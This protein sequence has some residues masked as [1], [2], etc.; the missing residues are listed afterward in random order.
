[1]CVEVEFFT[2][3]RSPSKLVSF[4]ITCLCCGCAP[5][6]CGDPVSTLFFTLGVDVRFTANK[7]IASVALPPTDMNNVV[8]ERVR[9]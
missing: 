8:M 9:K 6:A 7:S 1:M 2:V 3:S 5:Y 4:D